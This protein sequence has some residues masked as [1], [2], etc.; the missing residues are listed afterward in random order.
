VFDRY[1]CE[2]EHDTR[3]QC[4]LS[5]PVQLGQDQFRRECQVALHQMSGKALDEADLKKSRALLLSGSLEKTK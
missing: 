3:W 5:S 2:P 4:R 1:C